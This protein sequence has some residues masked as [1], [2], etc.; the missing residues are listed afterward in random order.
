MALTARYGLQ[1]ANGDIIDLGTSLPTYYAYVTSRNSTDSRQW[2]GAYCYFSE[3]SLMDGSYRTKDTAGSGNGCLSYV[4]RTYDKKTDIYSWVYGKILNWW[5]L[6]SAFEGIS[7]TRRLAVGDKVYNVS[8]LSSATEYTVVQYYSLTITLAFS[9][10]KTGSI[11]LYN[12]STKLAEFVSSNTASTVSYTYTGTS[13]PTLTVKYT[14]ASN[15]ASWHHSY[16]YNG[17]TVGGAS[18]SPTF[19]NGLAS[20]SFTPSNATTAVVVAI[21]QRY[22]LTLAGQTG[23][24]YFEA[25]YSRAYNTGIFTKSGSTELAPTSITGAAGG[26]AVLYVET[27]KTI[28]ASATCASGYVFSTES[29]FISQT[30]GVDSV[31]GSNSASIST[32]LPALLKN[33]AYNIT[34]ASYQISI[35]IS[36]HPTWGSVYIDSSGTTSKT[37]VQ[38]TTY[39][40]G[41]TSS[42][43]DYEAPTVASWYVNGTAI[44]GNTYTAST[45]SGNVVVTCTL[46]QNAW[47]VTVTAGS[48][49]SAAI[50]KR[51]NKTSGA[52]LANTG[53]LFA[54]GSDYIQVAVTPNAHYEEVVSSRVVSNLTA[55]ATGGDYCWS[56]SSGAAAGLGFSFALAECVVT[57]STSD[58]TLCDVSPSSAT[59][60]WSG[61]SDATEWEA[62]TAYSVGDW[63]THTSG[64]D[65][66]VYR[67]AEAHTS[68]TFS[69]DLLAGKWTPMFVNVYC[70]LKEEY[71]G[72]YRVDY[73]T[74]G[75]VQRTD[76][77]AGGTG[78]F[79]FTV[80]PTDANG[81]S[82]LSCVPHL[83][84]TL[85]T[86]TVS[87]NGDV[88]FATVYVKVGSATEESI[89]G[90]T[91]TQQVRE[92]T[93]V[94]A[95]AVAAFGGSIIAITPTGFTPSS[96]DASSIAFS[97]PTNAAGV[98][99][100]IAEKAKKTLALCVANTTTPSLA[101]GKVTLTAAWSASVHEEVDT[102]AAQSFNV[103][104]DT[105]YT[106]TAD[107]TDTTYGFSG[108]YLNDSTIVS[109]DLSIQITLS[110]AAKY[111]AVYTMR[112]AETITV[113]YGLQSG[114][115][116][117]A[118][119]L[120][121]TSQP[122]GLTIT[123]PPDQTDPDKWVIGNARQIAFLVTPGNSV[124]SDI[125]YQWIPVRVEVSTS[126]VV[127]Y[128]TVWTY[129]ELNPSS[130]TG[131]FIMS[132][133][134]LVRLVFVKV[135]AAGYSRVQALFYGGSTN[136]M[137]E[138][139]VFATEMLNYYSIGGVAEALCYVGRKVVLSAS[140]KPGYAFSG[141]W[142]YVDG[143]AV[144]VES[145]GAVLTVDTVTS[146]GGEWYA[147]F[148]RT[149]S[150]IKAWNDGATPKT[151]E[152]RSK[153]Y[154]G[155]QFVTL[156]NVRVY[157]DEYPVSL[158]IMTATSPADV[159]SAGAHSVSVS[160]T[161]QSPR[162]LPPIRLE[163]YFAFKVQG[164]A[165][166]NHVAIASSMEGL[167]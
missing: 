74:I 125:A 96:Q 65:V 156:R 94:Q 166:I 104:E 138:L 21:G 119:T 153:V 145:H 6:T 23:V 115:D 61:V 95:R 129:D 2:C 164:A 8:I 163:K 38:G 4:D 99:F 144:P 78:Q 27:G 112:R 123:T 55:Y 47:P 106:L 98:E 80:K 56:L 17:M 30:T 54:D 83:V 31:V 150:A 118:V 37:L 57:T 64:E 46:A 102:L 87:K 63:I 76:G 139:A 141:W 13:I 25:S 71:V 103:Y 34:T 154:V 111:T 108:W 130:L 135:Q 101:V 167:K 26:S 86:L 128:R 79:Y 10:Q 58:P 45:L 77:E 18:V 81:L 140:P 152:W 28:S 48:G 92:N 126:A 49:G 157:S 113:S 110:A 107:D 51:Y 7:T 43:A 131:T 29:G 14:P 50:S 165:R 73:W 85:N 75:G 137:G 62:S 12:G 60:Y 15:N 33:T 84:S 66:N 120:P 68:G 72:D 19:S 105:S 133:Q 41:F 53:Y 32:T 114:D 122:F 16:F 159:F 117:E 124:E 121:V 70:Q 161:S 151:F 1:K 3:K 67:C 136:E 134:M 69:D 147:S 52:E 143:V 158:T 39:T 91:F 90:G 97:M 42:R 20:Y 160:I 132:D 148:S 88:D 9:G 142:K 44:S 24:S 155:A 35:S 22:A 89:S 149:D 59:L 82:T 93:I 36:D 40:F 146:A 5:N 100:M 127:N 116:V 109:T 162:L 11:A